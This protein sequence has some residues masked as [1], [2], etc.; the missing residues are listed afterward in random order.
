[1]METNNYKNARE[2]LD[3]SFAAVDS[4]ADYLQEIMRIWTEHGFLQ[5][6]W[7]CSL[8]KEEAV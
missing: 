3:H 2:A 5:G 1:M 8:K 7:Q 4:A 6:E